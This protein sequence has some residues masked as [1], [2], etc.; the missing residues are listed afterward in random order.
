M[1]VKPATEWEWKNKFSVYW[2]T[3]IVWNYK[4]PLKQNA[5][6]F[7]WVNSSILRILYFKINFR[8]RYSFKKWLQPCSHGI[9]IFTPKKA[10]FTRSMQYIIQIPYFSKTKWTYIFKMSVQTKT[11]TLFTE[12][13]HFILL[14][15]Y[16]T[17][18]FHLKPFITLPTPPPNYKSYIRNLTSS[19]TLKTHQ[20]SFAVPSI[21][22]SKWCT[23]S[24]PSLKLHSHC[25]HWKS[26]TS[27]ITYNQISKME[28]KN[29]FLLL[30]LSNIKPRSLEILDT[31]LLGKAAA[32]WN[33]S[34]H[35]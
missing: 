19:L 13:S 23:S 25:L 28:Q 9:S 34:L 3:H 26:F 27:M 14:I 30:C 33:T 12:V 31:G 5:L 24:I 29:S 20:F 4:T 8:T 35:N 1:A 22:F 17:I 6:I 21:S 16:P 7:I 15:H 18:F 11:N 2:E 32:L 10:K